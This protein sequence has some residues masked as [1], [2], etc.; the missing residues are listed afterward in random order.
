MTRRP[1]G[2]PPRP[3]PPTPT[4]SVPRPQGV[5][6]V[7]VLCALAPGDRWNPPEASPSAPPRPAPGRPLPPWVGDPRRSRSG[8]TEPPGVPPSADSGGGWELEERG[9]GVGRC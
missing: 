5:S 6:R 8:K 4:L 1:L 3:Q 2:A 9:K 7:T